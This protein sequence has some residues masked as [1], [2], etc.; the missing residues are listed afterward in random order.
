LNNK[1][2]EEKYMRNP[3]SARKV[4]MMGRRQRRR[5]STTLIGVAAAFVNFTGHTRHSH[6]FPKTIRGEVPSYCHT[7][8]TVSANLAV[9][10]RLVDLKRGLVASART[11]AIFHLPSS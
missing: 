3:D 1:Q 7:G 11:S 9:D 8:N 10:L 2:R 4:G 6:V 5:K